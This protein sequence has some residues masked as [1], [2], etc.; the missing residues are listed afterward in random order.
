MKNDGSRLGK[1]FADLLQPGEA[2]VAAATLSTGSIRRAV[3][4]GESSPIIKLDLTN[5][6]ILMFSSSNLGLNLKAGKFLQAI[7]LREISS[8][9][10]TT[11]FLTGMNLVKL[12]ITLN[13][14]D[15]LTFEASGFTFKAAK[16]L[17]SALEDVVS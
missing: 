2:F 16:E 15:E 6:R 14:G 10:S 4:G 3:Y 13:D 1:R 11:G 12:G 5:H 8:V 7:P 9:E 17:A